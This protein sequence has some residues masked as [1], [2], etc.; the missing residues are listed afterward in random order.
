LLAASIQLAWCDA[1]GQT[2]PHPAYNAHATANLPR[3][4]TLYWHNTIAKNQ[5]GQP[6]VKSPLK[7]RARGRNGSTMLPVFEVKKEISN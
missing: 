4:T 3:D 5:L 7:Q 2:F 1:F 6:S